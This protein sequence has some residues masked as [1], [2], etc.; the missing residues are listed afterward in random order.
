MY[1]NFVKGTKD[2]GCWQYDEL[3]TAVKIMA[4]LVTIV[5]SNMKNP[6]IG[7]PIKEPYGN[8]VEVQA[9]G[10]ALTLMNIPSWMELEMIL[11][12]NQQV[13][14]SI[15]PCKFSSF[16]LLFFLFFF[17]VYTTFFFEIINLCFL[18]VL[19]VVGNWV[20][21]TQTP[22]FKAY[23]GVNMTILVLF[24]V[25][26]LNHKNKQR[27]DSCPCLPLFSRADRYCPLRCG[28]SFDEI[29]PRGVQV[30][31]HQLDFRGRFLLLPLPFARART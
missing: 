15:T 13:V 12:E 5:T 29:L 28:P 16:V 25:S 10:L 17:S 31:L 18:W 30:K 7:A 11:A 21:Y 3:L 27:N 2:F 20:L 23:L 24:L 14:A 22:S 6:D 4:P 26:F 8:L 9:S 1:V 19:Q